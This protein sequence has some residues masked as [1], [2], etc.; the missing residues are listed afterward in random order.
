MILY[1]ALVF[2]FYVSNTLVTQG[3]ILLEGRLMPM[4]FQWWNF[5][6][7]FK[8]FVELLFGLLFKLNFVYLLTECWLFF[9]N[10]YTGMVL[11]LWIPMAQRMIRYVFLAWYAPFL[12]H[13]ASFRLSEIFFYDNFV[14]GKA[15]LAYCILSTTVK[16]VLTYII[17]VDTV[18]PVYLVLPLS[19]IV[20]HWP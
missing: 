2:S 12:P 15:H 13:Q 10:L 14:F 5:V 1:I 7:V 3:L 17:R 19:V 9:K 18:P 6:F 4:Y 11:E 8:L 20:G 16:V